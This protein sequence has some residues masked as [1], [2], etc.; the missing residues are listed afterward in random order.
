MARHLMPSLALALLL[1]AGPAGAADGWQRARWGMTEAEVAA[2]YPQARPEHT[3]G[4]CFPGDRSPFGMRWLAGGRDFRVT[5]CFAPDGR[6]SEVGLD[7]EG[8]ST[9]A[10]E[11]DLYARYGQHVTRRNL[12]LVDIV[13][14]IDGETVVTLLA[15]GADKASVSY[16]ARKAAGQGL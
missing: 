15:D 14:W 10:L 6:L 13:T 16:R 7:A 11:A 8:Q 9:F 4:K 5:F 1:A 2:A 12:D 3:S